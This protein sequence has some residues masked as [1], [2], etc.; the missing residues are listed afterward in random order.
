LHRRE[1]EEGAARL[2][3]E[4]AIALAQTRDELGRALD[5]LEA[6]RVGAVN[7]LAS[8]FLNGERAAILERMAQARLPAIYEW[9]ETA[10]EGG[11]LGY[12][13]RLTLVY[14]QVAVIVD[15]VLRG[16]QPATLPIEQPTKFELVINLKT[17]K[18]LG[19][20]VPPALLANADEAIE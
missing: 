10:E 14:R 1:L 18:A 6:G 7:V 8:P 17:A 16:A 2:G 9:P 20:E 11:L 13:A 4:L 5:Q 15:K 19:L 3:V 12:G